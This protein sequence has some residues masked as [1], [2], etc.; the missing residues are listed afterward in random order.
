MNGKT[1]I[2]VAVAVVMVLLLLVLPIS[3]YNGLVSGQTA[4]EEQSA[5]I[6]TQLQ[7]RM[8][9]IPN[10]VKTVK[11]FT[12]HESEVFEQVTAAREKL[13]NADSMAEKAEAN[14]E[15]TG[16]LN[17]LI[18]IA[19]S[20]PELKSD[21]VYTGL[22]DELAGTENRIAYARENYNNAVSEYNRNIRRFPAVIFAGML[23]FEKAEFFEA[24]EAAATAPQVD[25]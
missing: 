11:S 13:M 9:L 14:E 22:M 7:R 12:E 23:G 21:S 6:D 15:V 5:N 20:Y 19:E 2:V 4:I 18:A 16:A 10:L 1:G 17:N 25:L 8:D 24:D 3:T